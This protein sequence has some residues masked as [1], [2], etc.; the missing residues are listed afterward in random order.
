VTEESG[1]NKTFY[2]AIQFNIE[3]PYGFYADK[4]TAKLLVEVALRTHAN[5]L[6]VFARDPWGRVFY[7]GSNIYPK[8]PNAALDLRE[9]R[10]L[11]RE[12]RLRLIIMTDHTANRYVYRKHPEYAQ[13]NKDGE[14]I[15]LEHL[16][17]AEK[18]VDP[19]WPQICLNSPALEEYLIP[20]AEEAT[21]LV[22]PDGVLLDSFRYLPDPPKAC[23]CRYCKTRFRE[24]NNVELPDVEDEEDPTF[25]LAWEWRHKVTIESMKKIR[26][27]IKKAKPDTLFLYNSH[28]VGWAGRGNIIVEKTRDILDGVF[29]EASEFDIIDY[30]YIVMA[31]K[32]SKA[33]VNNEKAVLVS[34]NLFYIFRTVQSATKL[35]VKQGIRSIVAAGGYPI[36]TIFSSQF[37]EDPRALDYLAEVY[38]EIECLEDLLT[39][40]EPVKHAAILFDSETHDKYFWRKPAI[41]LAE[42]EGLTQILMSRNLPI[43]FIT[44]KDVKKVKDYN[45]LIAPTTAVLGDEEEE[46]LKN[47]VEGGG[48]L[49][50][51]GEFGIMRPDYTYRH[52]LALEKYLGITL[53]GFLNTGYIYLQL[54]VTPT[55]YD[56]YWSGLPKSVILGD[57]SLR[58]RIER[59]EKELG[60]LVRVRPINAKV[61]SLV[62]T[63]KAP[64]GYEYTLGRS[65]PPPDS[66]LENAAGIVLAHLGSG[67]ALYYA[68]RIGAHYSRLGHPDYAELILRPLTKHTSRPPVIVEGPE[69]LQ[70]EYY[71][72]NDRIVIH[73][74][75]HTYNQRILTAPTGP[76]KQALPTFIP[77]YSV[78]PP[79]TLIP[80]HDIIIKA[81]VEDTQKTYRAYEAVSRQELETVLK[82]NYVEAR[83]KNLEEYALVVIEPRN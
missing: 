8:H 14:V 78:H 7:E 61:L 66:N 9:L 20:E 43:E 6:I 36:A 62:K 37:F 3:D 71:R 60:D 34:R 67:L 45:I 22:S 18:V 51:T 27:A 74:V 21:R 31:T 33:L 72:K 53:E 35:A 12:N 52:A 64:Y 30:A 44:M 70:T 4:I 38:E 13:R 26:E 41:Y 29:A 63:T 16:P 76:S 17:T 23:Y 11:T 73:I 68:G 65:T 5:T 79:R 57:Q 46:I 83:L 40:L 28:P 1:D 49:L 82:R 69:T 59:T 56:D 48:V 50:A 75:N 42:L 81:R 77:P 19:H 15:V 55:I 80:I 39:G 54:D 47:Y 24:E 2:R 25:R 58:F 10:K 32:L